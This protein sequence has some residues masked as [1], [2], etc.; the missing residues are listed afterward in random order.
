MN[1]ANADLNYVITFVHGTWATYTPWTR[2]G[3]ELYQL[4]SDHYGEQCIKR[5]KWSG[6]NSHQA[7]L[8]AGN[9]LA[10]VLWKNVNSYPSA[11]HFI[12]SHS[13]GGNVVL[14]ALRDQA[15]RKHLSGLM[16]M[17]VPFIHC[18]DRDINESLGVIPYFISFFVTWGPL[19]FCFFLIWI[20]RSITSS[21]LITVIV[22]YPIWYFLAERVMDKRRLIIKRINY[23]I[24]SWAR[25]QQYETIKRLALPYW[26]TINIPM[27]CARSTRDEAYWGLKISRRISNFPY[28]FWQPQFQGF[29]ASISLGIAFLNIAFLGTVP[30]FGSLYSTWDPGLFIIAIPF[31]GLI[32]YVLFNL[33]IQALMLLLPFI[34]LSYF[35][36]GG[37]KQFD[38]WFT[39]ITVMPTPQGNAGITEETSSRVYYKTY[40]VSGRGL[41]HCLIYSDRQ[42]LQDV[43]D[44]ILS[45]PWEKRTARNKTD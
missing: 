3:S 43:N 8:K 12:I 2:K 10:K 38:S 16:F 33:V 37:E 23:S 18:E 42:F 20:L 4:L 28:L 1:D 11:K 32:V 29:L 14:Y 21:M 45:R 31:I 26:K 39:Y 27:F 30:F 13:H 9:C 6:A 44:L 36:F 22:L 35:V 34:T 5:F 41:R 40:S 19:L 25:R 7:R 17:G 15:L 24:E